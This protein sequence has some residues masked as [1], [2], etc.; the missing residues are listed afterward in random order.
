M[1][2][3]I[4]CTGTENIALDKF[5]ELQ[6]NLKELSTANYEKLKNSILK[7][8]FSFPVFCWKQKDKYYILDA[9]QRIKTLRKLISEGYS[10]DNLPTCYIEAKD[11]KEAGEKLLLLNIKTL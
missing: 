2:I 4:T 7:Y 11:K 1:K 10:I 6:G 9:H 5:I 3:K 8:G